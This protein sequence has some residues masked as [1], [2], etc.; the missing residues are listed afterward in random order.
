MSLS[1]NLWYMI[2]ITFDNNEVRFYKNGRFIESEQTNGVKLRPNTNDL[3]IGRQNS[4]TSDFYYRGR[5]DEVALYNKAL[6]GKEIMEY[7]NATVQ[8]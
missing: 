6:S 5:L 8:G 3:W 2:G 7:Y 4:S 1:N